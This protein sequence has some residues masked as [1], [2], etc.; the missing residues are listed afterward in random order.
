MKKVENMAIKYV[1]FN[2]PKTE[3]EVEIEMLGVKTAIATAQQRLAVLEQTRYLKNL[4]KSLV[5]EEQNEKTVNPASS[6]SEDK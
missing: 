1:G 6:C 5:A 3:E 4:M 2:N